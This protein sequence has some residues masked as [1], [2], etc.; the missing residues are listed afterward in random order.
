MITIYLIR[1]GEKE[2]T[3]GD[4]ALTPLGTKQA[5][6]TA[7]FLKTQKINLIITSP[8][9]RAHHTAK[10][11][12]THL[13][14]PILFD[15]RLNEKMN[16]GDKKGE[17]FE[18]FFNEWR[19]TQIDR[20]YKPIHGESSLETGKR[21][22]SVLDELSH[23]HDNKNIAVISHGGAIGEF[24]RNIFSEDLLTFSIDEESDSKYVAISECSITLVTNENDSFR[25]VRLND[26]THLST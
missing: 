26:T 14:L 7:Q 17:T 15:K 13:N 23:K 3:S 18:E 6:Q 25:L 21:F 11:I 1:H 22:K 20:N 4:P 12:S 8:R 10:I 19:K 16:W 24:L 2:R 9:K 5:I